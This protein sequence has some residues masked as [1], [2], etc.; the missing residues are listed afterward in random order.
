MEQTL[1][2]LREEYDL[3]LLK[4]KISQKIDERLSKH[5]REFFLREQLREIKH[6]L[7]LEQDRKQMELDRFRKRFSELTLTKEA[8]ERVIQELG[9]YEFMDDSSPE[10]QIVHQ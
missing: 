3:S 10:S 2:L 7:G 5:Q 6:E 8:K 4:E 9:R 1:L